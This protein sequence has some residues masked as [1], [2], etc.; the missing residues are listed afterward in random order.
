MFDKIINID[1]MLIPEVPSFMLRNFLFKM[2]LNSCK[3]TSPYWMFLIKSSPPTKVAPIFH[4]DF[5]ISIL[6]RKHHNR[7]AVLVVIKRMRYRYNFRKIVFEFRLY[8]FF[9]KNQEN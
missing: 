8:F 4:S 7:A 5:T 1:L 2:N 3:P 6:F 9:E